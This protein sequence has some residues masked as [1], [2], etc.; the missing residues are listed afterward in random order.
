MPRVL[1]DW[2]LELFGM[3]IVLVDVLEDVL[4]KIDVPFVLVQTLRLI[5][6]H[7]LDGSLLQESLQIL[8]LHSITLHWLL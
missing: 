2:I 6:R 1:S 4:S 8:L 3:V 5:K 7:V